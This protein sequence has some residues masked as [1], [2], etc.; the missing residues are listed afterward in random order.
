VTL[1]Q[2]TLDGRVEIVIVMDLLRKLAREQQAAII[3]VTHDEKIYD[4]LDRIYKL[5]D[6]QLVDT[7]ERAAA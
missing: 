4:R 1:G 6:G 5:R 7:E 3:A 2:R